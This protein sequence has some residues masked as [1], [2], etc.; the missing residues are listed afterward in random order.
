VGGTIPSGVYRLRQQ[1]MVSACASPIAGALRLTANADGSY[2]GESH[3]LS[4][5]TETRANFI[6]TVNGTTAYQS[7]TCGAG[8]GVSQ[9]WS[10]SML[11]NAGAIELDVIMI[12]SSLDILDRVGD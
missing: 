3:S 11:N 12:G 4:E 8:A 9:S 5:S 10:Y 2:T 7:F 6:L 1:F